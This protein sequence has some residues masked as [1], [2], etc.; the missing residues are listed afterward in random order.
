MNFEK[1][2]GF[3]EAGDPAQQQN[4]ANSAI[5]RKLGGVVCITKN[6][7][8]CWDDLARLRKANIPVILHATVTGWGGTQMEPGAPHPA[9]AITAAAALAKAGLVR[10]VILRIDPIIPTPEGCDRAVWVA[11]LGW[12]LGLKQV[13]FSLLHLYAHRRQEVLAALSEESKAHLLQAYGK[14]TRPSAKY[15]EAVARRLDP[16]AKAG[17]SFSACATEEIK[18]DYI[19]HCGCID[20]DDLTILGIEAN[21]IKKLERNKQGRKGCACLALKNELLNTK[22]QCAHKCAYCYWK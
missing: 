11:R 2:V 1:L 14:K 16:L 18:R 19:K 22:K 3:T 12:R 6:P 20:T 8:A 5:E 13:R 10:S 9:A 17:V 21:E 15:A 4:W 7:L